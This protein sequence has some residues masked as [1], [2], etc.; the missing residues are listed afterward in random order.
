MRSPQSSA[1][2]REPRCAITERRARITA[3]AHAFRSVAPGAHTASVTRLATRTPR[4]K[5][6][7]RRKFRLARACSTR[8]SNE[9]SMTTVRWFQSRTPSIRYSWD[10]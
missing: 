9:A 2:Q 8:V 10:G 6:R 4:R 1:S 5:L 7:F 3:G